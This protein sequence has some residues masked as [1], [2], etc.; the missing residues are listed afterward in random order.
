MDGTSKYLTPL[1]GPP[2][3]RT[4]YLTAAEDTPYNL[5]SER[6]NLNPLPW[7]TVVVKIYQM[8]PPKSCTR[9]MILRSGRMNRFRSNGVSCCGGQDGRTRLAFKSYWRLVYSAIPNSCLGSRGVPW[10]PLGSH[11]VRR[12]FWTMGS[13]GVPWGL[14]GCL[15]IPRGQFPWWWQKVVYPRRWWC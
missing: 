7:K 5:F 3:I 15:G 14:L 12:R 11:G 13:R 8:P 2:P 9:W 10:G 1:G 6:P 4:G